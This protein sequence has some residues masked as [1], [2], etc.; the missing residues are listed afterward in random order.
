MAIAY[1][2]VASG[3]SASASN[4]TWSHTCTGTQR[5]LYV[6][7]FAGA[8]TPTVTYNGVSM[9]QRDGPLNS[10]YSFYLANPASGANTVSISAG[11]SLLGG[12]SLSY[13]GVDQVT[14]V[15]ASNFNSANT[16]AAS[17][18][19]TSTVDNCWFV[20]G[21]TTPSTSA[22]AGANTTLRSNPA[23][24]GGTPVA[25]HTEDSNGPRTPA[26]ALTL[27]LNT[28]NASNTMMFGMMIRPH[29]ASAVVSRISLL[30]VGQS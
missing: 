11:S 4:V 6:F 18:S 10:G 8:G 24:A 9:T 12:V 5:F 16:T 26:G 15:D 7:V 25:M 1:D 2:A 19:I 17:L 21:G 27:N 23:F 20:C 30:G 14:P 28:S 13:T 3:S 29:T 22:T